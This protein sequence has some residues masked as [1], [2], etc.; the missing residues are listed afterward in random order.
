MATSELDKYKDV[1]KTVVKKRVSRI[2]KFHLLAYILG[3]I[4]IG[5]WNAGTFYLRDNDTLWFYLPLL[6]WGL[7]VMI[8]YV[9]AVSLFDEWWERDE[10]VIGDQLS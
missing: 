2:F 4:T 5:L 9:L 8:H 1:R 3:M 10:K 6:F 7:G